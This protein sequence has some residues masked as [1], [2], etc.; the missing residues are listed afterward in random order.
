MKDIFIF[1]FLIIAV[2]IQRLVE[3]TVAK[4][5]EKWMLR[6]GAK[7][8]GKKHYRWMVVIHTL[9]F[10]SFMIEK[11]AYNKGLSKYWII[12]LAMFLVAQAIRIWALLSLGKY[13]NTKILVLKDA[14]VIQRGPYRYI[15]HPNYLVVSLELLVFPL[16]FDA[17]GT[18]LLFTFLNAFLL[19]IRIPAEERAL[20]QS[21][22]YEEDFKG[23]NRFLPKLL[24]KCDS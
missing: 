3:L 1:A 22:E 2:V 5:N 19:S 20:K 17:Y 10:V 9:F 18:A 6:Q 14:R 4:A 16:V 15:K 24:H 8:F 11:V 21:T 13:W 7:E 12:F 23:Y